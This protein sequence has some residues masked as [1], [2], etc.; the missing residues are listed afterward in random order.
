MAGINGALDA[1]FQFKDPVTGLYGPIS[2]RIHSSQFQMDTPSELGE[3]L[4]K[5]RDDYNQPI[6]AVA[7]PQPNSFSFRLRGGELEMFRL[8]WLATV[9]TLTQAAGSVSAEAITLNGVGRFKL[10]KRDVSNLALDGAG[11]EVTGAISG[12]TLTVSAVASGKLFVGQVISGSGVTPST[13]ITALGTGTGGA[14]TYTVSDSQTVSSTT[15]TA[16]GPTYAVDDDF[17]IVNARL[18]I[19]NVVAGSDLASHITASNNSLPVLADY[20]HGAVSGLKLQGGAQPNI[21]ARVFGD[22]INRASLKPFDIQIHE[23]IIA[24]QEGLDL[25]ADGFAEAGFTARMVTPAGFT[26]PFEVNWPQG[27]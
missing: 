20:D 21:V 12:T 13:T 15:I 18:G 1:F 8:T 10:A 14:G 16:T 24:P 9:S 5:G 26:A 11:A 2:E 23:A 3:L 17:V 27:V 6:G 22:G 19:G 7:V 25:L 4:S